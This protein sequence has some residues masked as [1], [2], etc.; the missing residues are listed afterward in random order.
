MGEYVNRMSHCTVKGQDSRLGQTSSK[1]PQCGN[2]LQPRSDV[3]G[4]AL[5]GDAHF[6]KLRG[7]TSGWLEDDA[8]LRFELCQCDI[9][10]VSR[11]NLQ[12]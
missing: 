2:S 11:T 7:D 1:P 5:L 9:P 10:S 8:L 12:K 3:S 6:C 4:L